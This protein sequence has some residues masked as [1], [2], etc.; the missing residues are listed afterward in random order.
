VRVGF[1][2]LDAE[3]TGG[4]V[5]AHEL[6]RGL[7]ANGHEALAIFP[8]DGPM[9]ARV[10]AEGIEA[11]IQPLSRSYR[12]DES[13]RFGRVLRHAKLDL[14]DT[15]TLYV[16]NQLARIAARIAGVSI[17]THSHID[18]HYHSSPLLRQAQSAID[19]ATGS[20]VGAIIAVSEHRRRQLIEIGTNP[21]RIVVVHNGVALGQ[22][23]PAE[24]HTGLRLVCAARLAPVKG[25]EILLKALGRAG[26][27]I[28]I[29]FAGDDLELGGAY[30][31]RL[32]QL[33]AELG[34]SAR[35]RFLG[36][37]DDLPR[38]L[39]DADGLVLPSLAE[40]FPL[41]VLEAMAAGRA[42]VATDVGGTSEAVLDRVTGLLVPPND[43]DAL[44]R[45]LD[46]LASDARRRADFGI[47]GY[48][49][50]ARLFSTEQ[51][52]VRTTRVYE[53]VL[54]NS[55]ESR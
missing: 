55:S 1:L 54:A 13:V 16:G 24:P 50:T 33:A 4:Q 20:V 27:E 32:E 38:L 12:L 26:A 39:Q 15:H 34:L 19:R 49:R 17:V 46:E 3:V 10:R 45:A 6:M 28:A 23:L 41:V 29:D 44:A 35:T 11:M 18:E 53:Q 48:E 21:A 47:A 37:R 8:L 25:Q 2:L 22:L 36:Y 40:G 7:Q 42:V 51:M 31:Q 30:R 14:L 52:V 9:V 5:V 43:V